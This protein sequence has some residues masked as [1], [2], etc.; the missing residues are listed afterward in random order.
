MKIHFLGA[1]GQ[2]TGSRYLLEVGGKRLLIDC[3]LFQERAY[4]SRNWESFIIP[5]DTIDA[6]LLTHAHLDH[7][8]LLPKLVSHGYKGPIY[9]T[10]A[11][12]ELAEIIITDCAKI[13]E[14]DAKYK[15]KRHDRE[16][17]KGP[18]PVEPL[19][20]A[21]DAEEAM[22]LFQNICY[23]SAV[24][25]GDTVSVTWHDAGHILGSAMLEITAEEHGETKTIV[26]SGDIG[27]RDKPIICDPT[28]LERADY[29]VMESTYGDRDHKE[30]GDIEQ[31][32]CDVINETVEAG[33]NL[34]IPTFAVERAQELMYHI[35]RLLQ[36][37]KVPHLLTFLD[38]PMAV[39]VTDVFCRHREDMDE[40]AMEAIE[41]GLRL[42]G[43]P[44]LT[45]VRSSGE[46][47]A[48]NRINGSCIIMAGSG[49]CTAGRIKHHLARHVSRE[50]STVLFVGYQANGTLGR[51]LVSG[52]KKVRIHG[53]EHDVRARIAQIHGFS[54]HA[55]RAGLL[56]WVSHFKPAPKHVFL[57][58]GEREAA[59]SLSE[60]IVESLGC[61]VTI[62]D[63]R[64]AVHLA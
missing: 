49:M 12:R 60:A 47:K 38:S 34:I 1:A 52:K 64:D 37:D 19:Y 2:V 14:E 31:Q 61:K 28:F 21:K 53:K 63:Y 8:G 24:P 20:V 40:E 45:L 25:I 26:F 55:D 13:Q 43:F 18:H 54:A 5:P 30:G 35:G 46:S 44:G 36:A 27:Q 56:D 51:E 9:A 57:T 50:E 3:G 10:A 41:Q 6:V 48:I 62:P 42:F 11:S 39:N 22:R 58:H 15:K 17:R 7:T 4:R 59:A 23:G 16:G 32:L 33:G 29:V